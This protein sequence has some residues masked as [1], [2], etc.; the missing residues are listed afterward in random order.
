MGAFPTSSPVRLHSPKDHAP[1]HR[2]NSPSQK[3]AVP[4]L[5][6]RRKIRETRTMISPSARRNTE[7]TGEPHFREQSCH[8]LIRTPQQE[9]ME[10]GSVPLG[11]GKVLQCECHLMSGLRQGYQRRL[12][13]RVQQEC[14]EIPV[15]PIC[16]YQLPVRVEPH[17][18]IDGLKIQVIPRLWTDPDGQRQ[19]CAG[20]RAG[21]GFG[22]LYLFPV[23][24]PVGN[25][26][27]TAM[28]VPSA[29]TGALHRAAAR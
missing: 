4:E 27:H 18:C 25:S 2:E 22:Q 14:R 29:G 26:L 5:P 9:G 12:C 21:K 8:N 11:R 28:C 15:L 7:K 13:G 19:G 20:G 23:H 3:K 16:K 10:R 6:K 17:G 24:A 1:V